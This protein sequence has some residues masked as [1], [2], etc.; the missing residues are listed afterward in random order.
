MLTFH[1]QKADTLQSL[2]AVEADRLLATFRSMI[3]Y[4]PIV[5][6]PEGA[7]CIDCIHQKPFVVLA[8]L[9]ASS[10]ANETL[11][12]ACDITFRT[13]LA[14]QVIVDGKKSLEL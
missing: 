3:L 13:V 4:F 7:S 11:R 10:A 8:M 14:K 9:A 5:F 12:T 2:C 1:A 6:F